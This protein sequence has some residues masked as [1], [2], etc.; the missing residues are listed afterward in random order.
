MRSI[1]G[2]RLRAAAV[3]LGGLLVVGGCGYDVTE[4]PT[5]EADE[6]SEGTASSPVECDN[7]TQS[8][9]P[10][11]D[12]AAAVADLTNKGLL[13]VGVSADT[14]KLGSADPFGRFEIRGFDID[15][16]R[17]IATELGVK[18]RLQVI[19]A[20]DRIPLLESGEIDIVARN[21]TM[22]CARWEQIGFSAVYYNATQKVLVR[23]D[24]VA[25]FEKD[26]VASLSGKKVCAPAG[27]TSI[28]NIKE[29]QPDVEAVAASNHTGCL[30]KFQ[31]G[32]VDAIT[33]DDT[34]L[35]GLAAQDPYAEVPEQAKLTDEP[36]GIGA[37]KAD[38]DLIRFINSVLETRRANGDWQ[39]SYNEWLRP[40]LGD[41]TPPAP[42]YG[43]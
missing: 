1:R 42:T 14:L 9:Q 28:D 20:A 39:A 23:S 35:A 11:T 31:Q 43:R 37:N 2:A 41:A 18:V 38:V 6:T 12:R 5:P 21:M 27:S 25:A 34:V 15:V 3:V 10:S 7:A 16:A 33:G 13:V 22:N 8:Y 17:A 36:Y 19:S 32:E 30:V 26:G 24:D 40:Y 4:L 29:V